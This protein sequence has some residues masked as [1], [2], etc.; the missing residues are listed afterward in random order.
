[1][2][3]FL[4]SKLK[5]ALSPSDWRDLSLAEIRS[6]GNKFSSLPRHGLYDILLPRRYYMVVLLGKLI[7]C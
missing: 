1:M 5:I 3:S 7:N 4:D 2:V 6:S